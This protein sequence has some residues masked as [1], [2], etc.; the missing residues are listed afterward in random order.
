M[1][2]VHYVVG[3]GRPGVPKGSPKS[4]GGDR[5]QVIGIV[6]RLRDLWERGAVHSIS[7]FD[8]TPG[9]RANVTGDFVT[10][11]SV[12]LP[13]APTTEGRKALGRM[14]ARAAG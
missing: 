12:P 5:A 6:E 7:V 9:A 13:P 2:Q 10:F 8:V 4:V 14:L 1:Y 11:S 3:G